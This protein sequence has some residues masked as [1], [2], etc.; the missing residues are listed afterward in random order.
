MELESWA[1]GDQDYQI[2]LLIFVVGNLPLSINQVITKLNECFKK[3]HKFARKSILPLYTL[4]YERLELSK[5][6]LLY[7]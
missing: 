3:K 5:S 6:K 2:Y 1:N 7:L 4:Q